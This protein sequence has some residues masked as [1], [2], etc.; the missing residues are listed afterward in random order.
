[1]SMYVSTHT[2][3][4]STDYG[5]NMA[6]SL[7][8]CKGVTNALGLSITHTSRGM[9]DLQSRPISEIGRTVERHR[10]SFLIRHMMHL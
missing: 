6:F 7:D 9:H 5:P 1:M 8:R 10:L 2:Q 3:R 4:R